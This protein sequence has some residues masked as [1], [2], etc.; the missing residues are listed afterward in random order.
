MNWKS[1]LSLRDIQDLVYQEY[2]K[3]GYERM[4]NLSGY[5]HL[6]TMN[7]QTKAIYDIAELSLIASEIYE[8]IEAIR[9]NRKN[10]VY[11]EEL[12]DIV[13]RTLNFAS[14]KDIDIE[15]EILKKHDKNM[16]R[17]KLHGKTV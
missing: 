7:R 12:A 11:A 3:N 5:L 14:R 17:G 13:I 6:K 2:Q 9:E 16:K 15:E 1:D 8:A 4:W 10:F